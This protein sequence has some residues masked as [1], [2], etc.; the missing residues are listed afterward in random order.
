[1]KQKVIA[2]IPR[3]V[4][5]LAVVAIL[6]GA[7]G[8]GSALADKGVDGVHNHA[9]KNGN[10]KGG[11]DGNGGG[12][13]AVLIVSPNPVAAFGEYVVSG[14]GFSANDLVSVGIR[15]ADATYW[16]TVTTDGNGAF[17]FTRTAQGPGDV[18]HE[19]YQQKNKRSWEM[20]AS[21]TLTVMP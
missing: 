4:V 7:L 20:K 19:A 1:M 12:S 2:V 3:L 6:G 14:S 15:H 9:E 17:S 5:M 10:G 13:S 21:V 11:N 8:A 16:S 18:V